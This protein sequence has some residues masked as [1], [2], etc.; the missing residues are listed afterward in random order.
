[1][2]YFSKG[3][4]GKV[5]LIQDQNNKN[6][7]L[8]V[9]YVYKQN[10]K[11]LNA[12]RREIKAL[13]RLNDVAK[14]V[15]DGHIVEIIDSFEIEDSEFQWKKG[16]SFSPHFQKIV[17]FYI[18]MEYLEEGTLEDQTKRSTTKIPK[19]K[20]EIYETIW[21]ILKGLEIIQTQK[22]AHMDI[23]P[24][25]LMWRTT[26]YSSPVDCQK[27]TGLVPVFVDFGLISIFYEIKNLYKGTPFY[28]APEI[29][30]G[31]ALEISDKHDIYAVG[32][33]L[34]QMVND[35]KLPF[36][37]GS[38]KHIQLT[39]SSG[40]FEVSS[41]LDYGIYFLLSHMLHG[42][43]EYRMPVN[44]LLWYVEALIQFYHDKK[45]FVEKRG[46]V[47][48]IYQPFTELDFEE[49]YGFRYHTA[50]K[51]INPLKSSPTRCRSY[52]DSDFAEVLQRKM[53]FIAK[54][55]KKHRLL[56]ET[57]M[58]EKMEEQPVNTQLNI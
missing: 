32:V 52:P 16:D 11:T 10:G 34:Y 3:A 55:K 47:M 42:D 56:S 22:I 20:M 1:K 30:T 46:L 4:Y 41:K 58:P 49:V 37:G 13:Q 36:F 45:L 21:H 19:S 39:I 57:G 12:V 5:F 17:F 25:N 14:P 29:I 35:G 18:V 31:A 27:I 24:N 2:K 28:M 44:K 26:E 38:I 8:K 53:E 23:K 54:N 33:I 40:A 7:A 9:Q 6:L 50:M 51:K 15:K 43:P 48:N